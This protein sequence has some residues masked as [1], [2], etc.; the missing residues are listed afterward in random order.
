MQMKK[1]IA[2]LVLS[3]LAAISAAAGPASQLRVSD[4]EF[5][6]DPRWNP[7]M[8]GATTAA[9]FTVTAVDDG[10]NPVPGALVTFA[11][12]DVYTCGSFGG[13]HSVDVIADAGGIATSPPFTGAEI[14]DCAIVAS[15]PG[16]LPLLINTPVFSQAGVSIYSR[17]LSMSIET[18]TDFNV[19]F[20]LQ[21]MLPSGYTTS[22]PNAAMSYEI[23]NTTGD[24]SSAS[25]VGSSS[26]V[27]GNKGEGRVTL[28]GNGVAGSY[29]VVM[30]ALGLT[31]SM[32]IT[33]YVLNRG[34]ARLRFVNAPT[35]VVSGQ[36]LDFEVDASD[37]N[38]VPLPNVAI[39]LEYE[40][41]QF[42]IC[43]SDAPF[44]TR[45]VTDSNGRGAHFTATAGS[46]TGSYGVHAVLEGGARGARIEVRQTNADPR[47]YMHYQDMWWAGPVENGWGMSIIQHGLNLFTVIFA[48]DAQGKPTWFVLPNGAW[49]GSAWSGALYRP[50]SSSWI[51]YDVSKF[52]PGASVGT[53]TLTFSG[54]TSARLDYTIDGQSGTKTVVREPFGTSTAG[55]Q[56]GD[57]W[58]GGLNQNG[59]GI[60]I[61]QQDPKIFPIV[62]AYDDTG[63]P[64]W[65][66]VPA[67][68]WT[69]GTFEGRLYS[70]T[71]SPWVGQAYDA[72]RL[73][74]TDVGS[75]SLQLTSP[76]T[77]WTNVNMGLRGFAMGIFIQEF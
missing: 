25:F 26:V 32:P 16:G 72:S 35:D 46:Y 44:T 28:H 3:C 69:N 65:Y 45:A 38:G 59:W 19:E 21:V 6:D 77:I 27:T 49:N 71:G 75:I 9:G 62:Y 15:V 58:W 36:A 2:L 48:Y 60:A 53:A 8:Q 52:Q 41:E 47:R 4:P 74:A 1:C 18:G 73:R 23:V 76:T 70:T 43:V 50:H 31:A 68:T 33:Q 29:S 63:A 7:V 24:G 30:H 42:L 5:P 61:L 22:I 10:G 14:G 13:K 54:Y 67:G 37:G 56:L 11:L 51:G 20:A 66:V 40:C 34:D 12:S 39:R 17:A 55:G 57:M 64:T